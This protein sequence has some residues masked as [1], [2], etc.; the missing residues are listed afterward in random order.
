MPQSDLLFIYF[1][2]LSDVQRTSSRKSEQQWIRLEQAGLREPTPPSSLPCVAYFVTGPWSEYAQ[3]LFK[4]NANQNRTK[5]EFCKGMKLNR[6][7]LWQSFLVLLMAALFNPS[8]EFAF[9]TDAPYLPHHLST[10]VTSF[11]SVTS[12]PYLRQNSFPRVLPRQ[13]LCGDVGP[14][15]YSPPLTKASPRALHEP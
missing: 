8:Q 14:S 3:D 7:R 13:P 9:A 4:I 10:S 1:P 15:A 6:A 12:V 11:I 2:T 5:N